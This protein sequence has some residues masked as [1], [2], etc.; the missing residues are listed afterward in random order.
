MSEFLPSVQPLTDEEYPI[1]KLWD[2]DK[3]C[4]IIKLRLTDQDWVDYHKWKADNE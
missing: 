3:K 1:W 4:W 2:G